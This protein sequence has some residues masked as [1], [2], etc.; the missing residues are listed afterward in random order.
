MLSTDVRQGGWALN[1][2]RHLP[3][4]GWL[5]SMT[6]NLIRVGRSTDPERYLATDHIV[7]FGEVPAAPAEEQLMGLPEDQRFCAGR[8]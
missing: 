2:L 1:G 6:D 8:S 7:W 5:G 4:S 3:V